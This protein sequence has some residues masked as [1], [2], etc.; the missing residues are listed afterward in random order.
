VRVA[1]RGD[2]L[3]ASPLPSTQPGEVSGLRKVEMGCGP[4]SV[5]PLLFPC[6]R[7]L[8]GMAAVAAAVVVVVVLAMTEAV[9]MVVVVVVMVPAMTE[10]VVVVVLAMTEAVVMVV[11]VVLAMTEA[12]VTEAV[13]MVVV[14]V[15]VVLAMSGSG[16]GGG[17]GG[18]ADLFAGFVR[19]VWAR[20]CAQA[21]PGAAS[22]GAGPAALA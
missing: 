6:R 14:V 11:A 16:G 8:R 15:V 10:A 19:G 12:V 20:V 2:E 4:A 21:Q 9:V 22:L 18:G 5:C 3:R 1:R 17:G 7:D 13:V